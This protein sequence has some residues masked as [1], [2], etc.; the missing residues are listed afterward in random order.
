MKR[1]QDLSQIF[2]ECLQKLDAGYS[3]D[4]VLAEYPDQ[5]EQLSTL[6]QAA[7]AVRPA[8]QAIRVPASAQIDSRRRFLAKASQ[9]KR[10]KG[11][12]GFWA[13]L[14]FT[15]RHLASAA[16]TLAALALLLIA[17]GSAGALP[18]D[19]LYPVKLT[20]EGI[21]ASLAGHSGDP[22]AW[23]TNLDRRRLKEV[24]Q[25]IANGRTGTVNFSGFL[26]PAE[27]SGWLVS[28]IPLVLDENQIRAAGAL[29]GGYV[30][31][32][33]NVNRDGQVEVIQIQPRLFPLNGI[34]QKMEPDQWLVNDTV[35][36]LTSDT[37]ISGTPQAGRQVFIQAARTRD[38]YQVLAVEISAGDDAAPEPTATVTP[39]RRPDTTPLPGLTPLTVQTPAPG[40][41]IK[42]IPTQTGNDD[43]ET[44]K[45]PDSEDDS[46]HEDR[47]AEDE[48]HENSRP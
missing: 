5:A 41:N 27:G 12:A 48:G 10:R 25:M 19:G 46:N 14:H 22:L 26:D 31:V 34:L 7:A 4:Q 8:G 23:E 40:E 1:Q 24:A 30:E 13:V 21:G 38:A 47:G 35:V 28:G 42:P 43:H 9:L 6:L 39:T 29:T 17:F 16:F 2:A 18:G 3:T 36:L 32:K 44:E 37:R 33:G 11:A 20:A 45:P 15:R